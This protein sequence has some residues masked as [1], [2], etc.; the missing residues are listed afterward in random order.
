MAAVNEHATNLIL[1]GSCGV[2]KTCL[3]QT[4]LH[5]KKI[6]W[7]APPTIS[8]VFSHHADIK[9]RGEHEFEIRDSSG[10][11][12]YANVRTIAYP[13]CQ[14]CLICFSVDSKESF[15]HL[16]NP[17]PLIDAKDAKHG[18]GWFGEVAHNAPTIKAILVGTKCDTPKDKREVSQSE[19]QALATKWKIPYYEV[20]VRS[21]A[22]KA[23]D[24]LELVVTQHING[25]PLVRKKEG[26]PGCLLL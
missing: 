21:G 26:G 23:N 25:D 15:E 12:K 5:Q 8:D 7:T 16:T 20:E 10:S 11:E 19:A 9:N 13:D 3:A 24:L 1:V 2:G 6:D 17:P 4:I 18:H 14:V 22:E